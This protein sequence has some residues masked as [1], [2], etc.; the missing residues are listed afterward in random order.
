[1]QKNNIKYSYYP[2]EG[3]FSSGYFETKKSKFYS[4]VYSVENQSD[5]K[6]I[7]ENIKKEHRGAKHIVYSYILND[8]SKYTDDGEP[9]GTAGKAIYD[10]LVRENIT[11]TLVIVVR[12]FG[13]TLLGVGPLSRAYTKS[14]KDAIG[15]CDKKE[16]VKY[17][18]EIIEC[19]YDE[20]VRTK[21]DLEI[22]NVEI[23]E[24]KYLEKVY[25][26]VKRKIE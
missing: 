1:M 16:Y 4:Y 25:I 19:E 6:E 20:E 5:V 2:K 13:G 17:V 21:K 23:L 7:L 9:Q 18:E 24:T 15:K 10:M 22:S 8:N 26:T 11:G 12:Y 14:F 3:N